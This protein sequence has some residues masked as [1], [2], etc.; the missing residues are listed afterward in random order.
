MPRGVRAERERR[1]PRRRAA[2]RGGLVLSV[3]LVLVLGGCGGSDH[4]PAPRAT[5]HASVGVPAT[6][7]RHARYQVPP[8][9]D[10]RNVYAADGA[11]ELS[12]VV[13]HFRPLIYVPNSLSNTV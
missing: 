2:P 13:R 6:G 7:A 4:D 3:L 9:L 1:D 8:L 11:G 12:P 5:T 10:P